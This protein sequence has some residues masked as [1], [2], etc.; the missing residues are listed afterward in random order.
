MRQLEFFD[1]VAPDTASKETVDRRQEGWYGSCSTEYVRGRE[2]RRPGVV[3]IIDR[4]ECPFLVFFRE[5]CN[6]HSDGPRRMEGE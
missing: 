6:G 3:P 1:D 5:V 4:A 2:A